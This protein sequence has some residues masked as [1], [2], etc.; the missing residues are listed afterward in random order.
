M[1]FEFPTPEGFFELFWPARIV[2]PFGHER[3]PYR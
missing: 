1:S 2:H 3:S